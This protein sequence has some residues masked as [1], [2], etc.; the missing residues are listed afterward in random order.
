MSVADPFGF[1][2]A[3][4]RISRFHL[5]PINAGFA[6]EG[7][8]TAALLAFHVARASKYVGISWVGNV[9]VSS[10][11]VTNAN[12]PTISC[13]A[14]EWGVLSAEIEQR[15][16]VPGVQLAC[17][18]S[19]QAAPTKWTRSKR[20]LYFQSHR[21][22]ISSLS[23]AEIQQVLNDFKAGVRRIKQLG[24]RAVQFHAAHGYFLNL[25][26]DP[27][28]NI[29][30]DH[31][32]FADFA[33]PDKIQNACLQ[34]GGIEQEWRIS[35]SPDRHVGPEEMEIAHQVVGS[36]ALRNVSSINISNG[37]Y[38]LDK[39]AIYPLR[40]A[41]PIPQSEPI[42]CWVIG[43][44][45]D[46]IEACAGWDQNVAFYI[47]RALIADAK[48]VEKSVTATGQICACRRTNKCHFYSRGASH[49][50]CGVNPEFMSP[51]LS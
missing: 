13:G 26:L 8:P 11:Y 20:D 43:G 17:R 3:K 45:I 48:F 22:F 39:G 6:D 51:A 38:D 31:F 2:F 41:G 15:G 19:P 10:A 18:F 35:L 37:H 4:E 40:S 30:T 27:R 49:I 24:F 29:R 34:I 21:R 36:L 23:A 32:R 16:S 1:T 50:E 25:L 46:S 44:N 47:G 14:S 7:V 9:A 12:T 42:L 28:I 33:V 5:A